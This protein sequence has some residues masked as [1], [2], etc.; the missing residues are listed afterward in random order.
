L[1]ADAHVRRSRVHSQIRGLRS[2][3]TKERT[4]II[5]KLIYAG[6]TSLE[7]LIDESDGVGT[8][9]VV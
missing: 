9:V 5:A 7:Q 1:A 4:L 2:A 3:P 8:R 6:I